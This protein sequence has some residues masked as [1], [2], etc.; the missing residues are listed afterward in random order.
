MLKYRFVEKNNYISIISHLI[1]I[2]KLTFKTL[3]QKISIYRFVLFR[4]CFNQ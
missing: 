1:H 3:N 2:N 4:F